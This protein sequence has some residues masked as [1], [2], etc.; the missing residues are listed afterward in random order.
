MP[1]PSYALKF[2]IKEFFWNT[3]VFSNEI[4]WYSQTKTFRRKN[5][6]PPIMKKIFQYPKFSE[7]LKGSPQIFPALW[8][9]KFPA[10]KRDTPFSSTKHLET[11]NFLKNSRIPLRNFSALWDMKISTENRDMPALIHN[12]FSIP[13]VLWKTEIFLYKDFRFCAVRQKNSA[14]SWCPPPSYV[15][16]FSI[17]ELFWNTTVFSNEIFRYSQT[18]NFRRKNV[19][20]PILNKIFRYPNFS[21]TLKGSPQKNSALWG[22]KFPTENV[23][24]PVMHKIFRYPKFPET[25]KGCPRKV[26][27][28][29]DAIFST[30]N[31]IPPFHQ[32]NFSKP[33]IFSKTVGIPYQIF[34]TVRHKN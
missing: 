13:E 31:V 6:I 5:V 25:F 3:T 32:Q 11:R 12:F 30:E 2:S 28:L 10:E 19:I 4:I 20:P 7:T 23:L 27:A 17:K 26:S 33:E 9:Q 16:K 8:D 34:C 21:E 29:W 18:E 22:P 15:W 24:P 1:H 14:K